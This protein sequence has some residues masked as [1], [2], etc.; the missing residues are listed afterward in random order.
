[1]LNFCWAALVL[2]IIFRISRCS[3]GLKGVR[4]GNHRISSM[5]FVNDVVLS[6]LPTQ[7]LQ[8]ALRWFAA[9]CEVYTL[10]IHIERSQLRLLLF[11]MP[12][13]R[14]PEEVFHACPRADPGRDPGCIGETISLS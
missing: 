14:L 11:Q 5:L 12:P 6:A 9:K 3:E 1:M 13:R 10:L 8:P 7:D 4:F 2:S